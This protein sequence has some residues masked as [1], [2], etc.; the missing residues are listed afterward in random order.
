MQ[1]LNQEQMLEAYSQ[2]V[3]SKCAELGIKPSD[4][5]KLMTKAA[6]NWAK[7]LGIGAGAAGLT[8]IP[9]FAGMKKTKSLEPITNIS[10]GV[11]RMASGIGEGA[12]GAW[13]AYR[14]PGV[15]WG[16]V[17][18]QNASDMAAD[19][20]GVGAASNKGNLE[21]AR[22]KSSYQPN[23]SHKNEAYDYGMNVM[24]PLERAKSNLDP[25]RVAEDAK[26]KDYYKNTVVK[27]LGYDPNTNDPIP[28][29]QR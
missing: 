1:K 6:A 28:W 16:N 3:M 18:A 21:I 9:Y 10:A 23:A 8:S 20:I 15:N 17:R 24:T 19:K 14:S 27:R 13:G 22:G 12:G 7:I 29:G 26:S 5:V 4:G 25:A 2:G 11:D